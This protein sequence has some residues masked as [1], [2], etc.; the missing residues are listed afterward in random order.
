MQLLTYKL[1]SYTLHGY[2]AQIDTYS[3]YVS[4]KLIQ[5]LHALLAT[6]ESAQELL[7]VFPVLVVGVLQKGSE[8]LTRFTQHLGVC[9]ISWGSGGGTHNTYHSSL[10]SSIIHLF[11]LSHPALFITAPSPFVN[12]C[13]LPL[14]HCPLSLCHC[15]GPLPFSLPL[16][17]H[18]ATLPQDLSKLHSFP[19][20]GVSSDH[21]P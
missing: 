9:G 10:Q 5:S 8:N 15:P 1:Y 18:L 16:T 19:G 3:I 13:P 17:I 2:T 4:P 7:C 21:T 20:G 14:C 11:S 6:E 12:H